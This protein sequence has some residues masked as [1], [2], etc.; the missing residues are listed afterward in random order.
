MDMHCLIRNRLFKS[1]VY[2]YQ[3]ITIPFT[4]ILLQSDINFYCIPSH[5]KEQKEK[6]AIFGVH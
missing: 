3:K 2:F 6:Q 1:I 5:V 4:L